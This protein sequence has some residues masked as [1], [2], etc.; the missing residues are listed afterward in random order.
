MKK[1]PIAI[2]A[3]CCVLVLAGCRCEH[4]WIEA[5]CEQPKTCALCG[6]TEGAPLGHVWAAAT[7][8]QAQTCKNCGATEGEALGH[9]WADAT[10]TEPKTCL[11]CHTTE[12]IAL[13]HSWNEATT[14]APKTCAVCGLTEGERIVTDPRFTT[15]ACQPL[16]GS[17]V[18]EYTSDVGE[19][20]GISIDGEDLRYTVFLRLSFSNDGKLVT[21][22]NYPDDNFRHI[23]ELATAELTYVMLEGEGISRTDADTALLNSAGMTVPEY[24]AA[25]AATVET[26]KEDSAVYYVSD[27]A[28]YSATD[29]EDEL[30]G[31]SYTL[32]GDSLTLTLG[33]R[34][35]VLHR[36]TSENP[37]NSD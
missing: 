22:F 30:T 10:C 34:Q 13:G 29:W 14:E 7:C 26:E 27:G 17:W 25:Y 35:I 16:F 21:Y 32:E 8:D 37:G 12:G 19:E 6:E 36:E 2:L 28:I 18:C 9:D 23:V 11:R 1:L 24:A 5:N 20:L 33:S 4:E 3:L 15:A 31:E